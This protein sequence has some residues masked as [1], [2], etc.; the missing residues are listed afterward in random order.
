MLDRVPYHIAGEDYRN[1]HW[2]LYHAVLDGRAIE[3]HVVE[4]GPRNRRLRQREL[5][6]IKERD[7]LKRIKA[8]RCWR[9]SPS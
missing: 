8:E 5:E 9:L 1:I 7:T 2:H 6:L 4:N 3:W